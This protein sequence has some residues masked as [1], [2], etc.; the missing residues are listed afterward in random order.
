[1]VTVGQGFHG[2][3]RNTEDLDMMV[4]P[5]KPHRVTQR[6]VSIDAVL[7]LNRHPRFGPWERW[8]L[9]KGSSAT[10]LT[11]LGQIDVVQLLPGLRDWS[12]LVAEAE[13]YE[14]EGEIVRVMNR[15][16]WGRS[17]TPASPTPTR[18]RA[19]ASCDV[20]QDTWAAA[21]RRATVIDQRPERYSSSAG[22]STEE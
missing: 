9:R 2:R 8:G 17:S 19:W 3:V 13:V 14:V 22:A 18:L 15:S 16:T 12:T 6:L 4:A 1:V 21:P 20:A 7:K 11:S 5:T 10:V